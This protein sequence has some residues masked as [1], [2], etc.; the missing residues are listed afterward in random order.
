MRLLIKFLKKNQH[1]QKIITRAITILVYNKEGKLFLTKRSS[2]KYRYPLYWDFS[3]GGMVNS[4]EDYIT[5]AIRELKEELGIISKEKELIFVTNKYVEID[6]REHIILFKLIT[7]TI[8]KIDK[9]EVESGIFLTKEEIK[10]K[11]N[12]KEKFNPYLLKFIEYI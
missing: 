6:K 3:V 8:P 12:N 11:L 1:F 2:N 7:G 9:S 10:E 4:E 5:V